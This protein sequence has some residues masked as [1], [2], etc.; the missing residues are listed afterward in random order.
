MNEK[1]TELVN[2]VVDET[3]DLGIPEWLKREL[4]ADEKA[5]EV[6]FAQGKEDVG[7]NEAGERVPA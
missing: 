4:E 7:L 1:D 2:P 3:E 5:E 6:F